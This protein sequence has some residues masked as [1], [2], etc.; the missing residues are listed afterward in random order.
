MILFDAHVH[1]HDCFNMAVMFDAAHRNFSAAGM[2]RG[3]DFFLLLTEGEKQNRFRQLR[4]EEKNCG[5][6]RILPT[7]ESC[8]LRL[9]RRV[10]ASAEMFVVAGRQLV[11]AEKLEV[12]ALLT[13]EQFEEGLPLAR[14]V[15]EVRRRGALPALP[16]GAGKWLG[17]R[18]R[19]LSRFFQEEA[20]QPLFLADN[21]CRP[22]LWPFPDFARKT[23]LKILA[24]TDPL[25]FIWEERRAGSYGCMLAGDGARLDRS[26]PAAGLG[27]LL[28]DPRCRPVVYGHPE[29]AVNF[30]RNQTAMQIHKHFPGR[31]RS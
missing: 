23:A 28:V 5:D 13:D 4:D 11:T 22:R 18:K 8:T 12:L 10:G 6:W 14:T 2:G 24:G 29:A 1:I 31:G 17:R 27:R 7:G 19:V 25:P 9:S 3:A 20:R 15:D 16:W 21:R 30:F 26:T